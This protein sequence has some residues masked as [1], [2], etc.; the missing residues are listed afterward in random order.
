MTLESPSCRLEGC[1]L[2][3]KAD[4]TIVLCE[5]AAKHSNKTEFGKSQIS[6]LEWRSVGR[7]CRSPDE[8]GMRGWTTSFWHVCISICF[9]IPLVIP[10]PCE[11]PYRMHK[12]DFKRKIKYFSRPFSISM[13]RCCYISR[14]HSP[15]A[16]RKTAASPCIVQCHQIPSHF[17]SPS[18]CAHLIIFLLLPFL[19]S[20]LYSCFPLPLHP[21]FFLHFVPS[22]WPSLAG[23][24]SVF[25]CFSL[26][27]WIRPSPNCL[28]HLNDGCLCNNWQPRSASSRLSTVSNS[29]FCLT[30]GDVWNAFSFGINQLRAALFWAW[31]C[32]EFFY[33]SIQEIGRIAWKTMMFLFTMSESNL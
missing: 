21:Q 13:E 1:S 7:Q 28:S 5:E 10:M 2:Q 8:R 23:L 32:S 30:P 11:K 16:W 31:K 9:S 4:L 27:V 18:L 14:L 24:P 22:P 12:I 26:A 15:R 19:T 25:L 17:E 29:V 3:N 33:Q 6:V 20:L